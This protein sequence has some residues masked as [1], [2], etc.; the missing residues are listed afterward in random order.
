MAS[1][2]K[3]FRA[4]TASFLILMFSV[5][6]SLVAQIHVVSPAE[7]QKA[8]VAATHARQRNIETIQQFLS[9]EKA[10]RALKTAHMDRQRV[11]QAVSPLDDRKLAQL[12]SPPTKPHPHFSAY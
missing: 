5:P 4:A 2:R 12:P 9:S 1:L 11:T 3:F 7:L 8:T 6:Q 10:Q